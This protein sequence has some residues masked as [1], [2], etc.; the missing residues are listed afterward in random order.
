MGVSSPSLNHF[1]FVLRGFEMGVPPLNQN[2]PS[3]FPRGLLNGLVSPLY[4]SVLSFL[5]FAV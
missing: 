5:A 2:H 1:N 3:F 4:C